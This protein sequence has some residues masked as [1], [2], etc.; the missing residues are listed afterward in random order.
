MHLAVG[1]EARLL[2]DLL[3]RKQ[4]IAR[5]RD[6]VRLAGDT[7]QRMPKIGAINL[8]GVQVK[9]LEAVL[10][11]QDFIECPLIMQVI[12]NHLINHFAN[13]ILPLNGAYRIGKSGKKPVRMIDFL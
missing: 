7:R 3:R 1:Q 4:P 13:L 6:D 9:D 10:K 11:K 12:F 8:G 5:K 2:N